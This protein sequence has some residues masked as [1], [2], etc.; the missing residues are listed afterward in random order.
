M[1][2]L[3]LTAGGGAIG[4]RE[5]YGF[6]AE[7]TTAGR[8]KKQ[9]KRSYSGKRA[10]RK[11]KWILRL[12]S[13]QKLI[14]LGDVLTPLV[15][16]ERFLPCKLPSTLLLGIGKGKEESCSRNPVE[17]ETRRGQVDEPEAEQASKSQPRELASDPQEPGQH[18]SSVSSAPD[19]SILS[20]PK[21]RSSK[22]AK[23]PKKAKRKKR[24]P[25][26]SKRYNKTRCF[27]SFYTK[28]FNHR[29]RAKGSLEKPFKIAG[30]PQ[31][32]GEVQAVPGGGLM[33]VYSLAAVP[34]GELRLSLVGLEQDHSRPYEFIAEF[35]G[36]A[37]AGR[38]NGEEAALKMRDMYARTKSYEGF[39][40]TFNILMPLLSDSRF[41]P[42]KIPKEL[43]L[44]MDSVHH[45]YKD[46][47]DSDCINRREIENCYTLWEWLKDPDSKDPRIREPF[48]T[49]YFLKH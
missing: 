3:S 48:Y 38:Y 39:H 2:Q 44:L 1:M 41:A 21:S 43:D 20:K 27:A 9:Q 40:A 17:A 6:T 14:S 22:K 29:L 26:K 8:K 11:L 13:K 34:G 24:K 35:V 16:D 49:K 10:V 4:K 28:A 12:G 33:Q 19:P 25:E 46:T 42:C 23:K 18:Q 32:V 47:I 36:S 37:A 30:M 31:R 5:E 15:A 45:I 7:I